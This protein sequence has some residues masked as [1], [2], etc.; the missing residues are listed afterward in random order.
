M[1]VIILDKKSYDLLSYLIR[2]KEAETVMAISAALGQSR[3]KIYYHLDKI[4]E[5]L[6]SH[7]AQIVSYPRVGILLN[8]EQKAACQQ[9]LNEVTDYHYVMKGD[10]RRSL[11]AIYIA[12]ATE[13][14]TLDKLMMINDVSRNTILNDLAELREELSS[15]NNKIQLHATKAKGYYFDCHPMALIQYLYK[16]LAGVYQGGNSS[17]I[18]LF[19]HKLSETQGLSAY[20]SKEVLDYF[21]EYLFLSQASLGKTINIQD[22][23]F[24]LQILPFI[25]L[26][27]RN[28][29]L[30][31][32]TKTAL[33]SD[34]NLI[35]KRKEYQIAKALASELYHNF[36]LHLDDI[37]V[38]MVAMLMLSFRKDQDHHVESQDYEQMRATIGDFI[39]QL[40]LRYQLHFTHKKDLLRQLTRHCKALVYRKAYGIFSINPLTDHIKEKYEELFAMAQSCAV[41]LEQAWQIRLTDDDVAYLTIHLGGELRHSHADQEKTKLVIVSDDGI[42]IQK[43][44]LKQCQRYLPNCQIEAVFTTEQYQSVFDL[45]SVDIVVSTTDALE[46]LVPI[47]IVNPILSDDDIIRLIRFSKQ[48]RLSDSSRFSLE[49]EKAIETI[50]KDDADR[51]AL[52]TKIEKLIH[53][54]LL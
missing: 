8:S 19:D 54:E 53:H 41:I 44:L 22:S 37:E 25:L 21:H 15:Y 17:F 5:A 10:E 46:A 13:R 24:M 51:Y 28:M 11:S 34:F 29:Q 52:K 4:N 49:L 47:L 40:E 45:M 6:P 43:L 2:L 12:V 18:E 9:L 33:K 1:N 16:V 26:S 30:H 39:D 38:G 50:V 20:F 23:Q 35:W 48:G 14:V 27:Y 32:E 42:G 36:K 31:S 7:V 3:R